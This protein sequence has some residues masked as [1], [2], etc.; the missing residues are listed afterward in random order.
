MHVHVS[1]LAATATVREVRQYFEG[2]GS[3]RVALLVDG[4]RYAG[5]V[6]VMG[7]PPDAPDDAPAASFAALEPVIA[8]EAPADEAR[9]RTLAE[10]TRRLPVIDEAGRLVGIVA[11]DERHTRFCGT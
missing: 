4:E 7:L 9:D 1:T 5:S 2:S 10:P 6:T 8:P 11:I 3:H